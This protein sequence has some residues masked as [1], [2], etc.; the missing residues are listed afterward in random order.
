VTAQPDGNLA[1]QVLRHRRTARATARR[2]RQS[3][4]PSARPAHRLRERRCAALSYPGTTHAVPEGM[5]IFLL[6][7]LA[8]WLFVPPIPRTGS[9]VPRRAFY[10]PLK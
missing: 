7:A 3:S 10:A 2:R 5:S 9:A 8:W 4:P 6:A 1:H